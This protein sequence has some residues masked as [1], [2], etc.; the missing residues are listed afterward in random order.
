MVGLAASGSGNRLVHIIVDHGAAQPTRH[1]S[2]C[3]QSNGRGRYDGSSNN[4]FTE[5]GVFI[6]LSLNGF[7]AVPTSITTAAIPWTVAPTSWRECSGFLGIETANV[8]AQMISPNQ[9]IAT[10]GRDCR[11]IAGWPN[12]AIPPDV[13]FTNAIRTI[14]KENSENVLTIGRAWSTTFVTIADQSTSRLL[15]FTLSRTPSILR[16]SLSP[17]PMKAPNSIHA[18][19]SFSIRASQYI[20]QSSSPKPQGHALVR[21]R[22]ARPLE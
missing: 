18:I 10:N 14:N 21:N 13:Q 20:L 9:R 19:A 7:L 8:P 22:S 4:D 2:I 16:T 5:L 12:T 11:R 1:L 6:N 3:V 17:C 15:L